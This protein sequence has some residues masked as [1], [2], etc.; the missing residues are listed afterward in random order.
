MI[1]RDP[2]YFGPILN[3]LRHGKL[4]YNK[5]LAE[6]GSRLRPAP[7]CVSGGSPALLDTKRS[8]LVVPAASRCPGGG[9]V[10]QHHPADQ[11]GE[12]EDRG[13][14]LQG[15]AGNLLQVLFSRNRLSEDL[16]VFVWSQD[17]SSLSSSVSCALLSS[18]RLSANVCRRFN[19]MRR[20][21]N[22][23]HAVFLSPT[24]LTEALDCLMEE[25][26]LR[27]GEPRSAIEAL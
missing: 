22:R 16:K 5:E 12:G 11:T 6:E 17:V 1:D 23:I 15:H 20:F 13:E 19:M 2:T 8:L 14:G 18:S 26:N 3:Y 27:H 4:V 7:R 25:R 9:R 21:K 10:L 24:G